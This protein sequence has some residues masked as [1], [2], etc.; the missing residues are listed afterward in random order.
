MEYTVLTATALRSWECII[1]VISLCVCHLQDSFWHRPDLFLFFLCFPNMTQTQSI[2]S[3]SARDTSVHQRHAEFLW[4][5]EQ[6]SPWMPA[7]SRFGRTGRSLWG[8]TDW[9]LQISAVRNGSFRN[10]MFYATN[11]EGAF[12][13]C[14]LEWASNLSLSKHTTLI[15]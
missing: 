9:R 14:V 8:E 4:W 6:K 3:I 13:N 10:G 1:Y 2:F 5:E 7:E 12:L 11:I 15:T